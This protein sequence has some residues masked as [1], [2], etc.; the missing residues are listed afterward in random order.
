MKKKKKRKS[1]GQKL[2]DAINKM[3]D[4]ELKSGAWKKRQE[5]A[6][7]FNKKYLDSLKNSLKQFGWNIRD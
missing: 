4:E 6:E 3:A 2:I 7:N 1:N 5:I